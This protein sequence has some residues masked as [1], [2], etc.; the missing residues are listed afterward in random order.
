[1]T[2]IK[3]TIT[4]V[5]MMISPLQKW[6][7]M[8]WGPSGLWLRLLH[9]DIHERVLNFVGGLHGPGAVRG[10]DLPIRLWAP[11]DPW[12]GQICTGRGVG[13][14]CVL[15]LSASD[16]G[17]D[18]CVFSFLLFLFIKYVVFC[19]FFVF[20]FCLTNIICIM[21]I[22]KTSVALQSSTGLW[23]CF[24]RQYSWSWCTS[25]L[26]SVHKWVTLETNLKKK[27]KKKKKKE[28]VW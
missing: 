20:V 17:R 1:M 19:F 26:C 10:H 18:V 7:W 9:E 25:A 28:K 2:M 4:T 24:V 14:V 12:Q 27:K 23:S 3:A 8:V 21:F 5:T 6:R 15:L 11:R 22:I 13:G 16:E